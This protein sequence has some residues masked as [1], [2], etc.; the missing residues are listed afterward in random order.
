MID[1]GAVAGLEHCFK[2]MGGPCRFRVEFIDEEL[3][4]KA[5]AAAQARVE[6]LE[7][8]YSRYREDSLL[9]CINRA[10]GGGV[11]TPVDPETE[12]L[13]DYAHTLW[14]QSE[15]L[16]DATAGVLRRAW[17]F[18]SARVPSQ[19]ELEPLLQRIGWERVRRSSGSVMLEG[20]GM[21]LDFGG[22]VKEYAADAAVTVLR[23]QGVE[24]ALVDL[25]GDM[26]V[27][28]PRGDGS[29]WPV[30]IRNPVN[31]SGA[32][33]SLDLAQGGLATSGDYERLLEL[34]GKR[35][36]HILNPQTGWPVP[37]LLSVSV[38]AGQCLVAGS[39]AT[40]ALLKPTTEAL[41]WLEDLGL[42]WLAVDAELTCHGSI[43]P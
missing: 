4:R 14:Q 31:L 20:A 16:F 11:P 15:G 35:Y 13:L 8:R 6:G 33:A 10:A 19:R 22:F 43:A 42:P 40:I 1:G 39:A 37:G 21:E 26:A 17:D 38:L 28:G 12:S 36:G 41:P 3:A 34:E 27:T 9:S 23:D 29:P 5:I 30:G 2:A 32:L 25:A 18:R 7:A 24:H